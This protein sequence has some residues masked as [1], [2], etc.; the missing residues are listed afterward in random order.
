MYNVKFIYSLKFARI[1]IKCKELCKVIN[2]LDNK[3]QILLNNKFCNN[4]TF[5]F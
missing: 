4:L 5:F 1:I 2:F 3:S